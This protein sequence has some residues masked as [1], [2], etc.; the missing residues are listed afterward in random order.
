MPSLKAA[1]ERMTDALV[2]VRRDFATVRTG[3]ASP[4]LLDSVRVEAYGSKMHLNQVASIHT[5]E[6]SLLVV[7]PF[8]KTLISDIERAILTAD[9]GLNPSS[10]GNLVRVPIPPLNEERRREYVRLLHK[11]AEEARVSVRHARHSARD[12]IK[13]R[14]HH[15]EVSEDQGRGELDKIQEL[16]DQHIQRIDEALKLKE[17]EVMQV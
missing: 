11:M 6:A 5:P 2:A 12:D 4:A 17:E 10:D 15:H 7:Q 16:T 1:E 14:I 8:D 9:L 13:H 3:K